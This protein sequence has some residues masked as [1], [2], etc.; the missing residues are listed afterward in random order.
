MSVK[1]ISYDLGGPETSGDYKKIGEYM[2]T[3]GTRCKPLESFWLVDTSLSCKQLRDSIGQY[4]D[5]N[6]KLLVLQWNQVNW[7][8]K[9]M[10]RDVNDWLTNR[11]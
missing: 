9:G 2:R 10:P 4:L 8:T 3:F 6:D 11:T 5:N 1:I 7:A